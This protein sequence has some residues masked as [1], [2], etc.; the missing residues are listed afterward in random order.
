MFHE[1]SL[2]RRGHVF[3]Q[4]VAQRKVWRDLARSTHKGRRVISKWGGGACISGSLRRLSRSQTSVAG[5]I[6]RS[7][8][9]P[10]S[11]VLFVS[12]VEVKR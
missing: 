12:W 4:A 9:F 2:E 6:L 11:A 3:H 10:C 7:S 5:V 8:S 1:L